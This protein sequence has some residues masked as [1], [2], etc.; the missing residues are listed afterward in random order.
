MLK[1]LLSV[2]LTAIV[3]LTT[4]TAC[5]F[6]FLK[7]DKEKKE[8]K[9]TTTKAAVTTTTTTVDGGIGD[10]TT[11]TVD[12]G[13]DTTTTTTTTASTTV[14]VLLT[15]HTVDLIKGQ[16]L[17]VQLLLSLGCATPFDILPAVWITSFS[18]AGLGLLAAVLLGRVWKT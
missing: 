11:T 2:L 10:T 7:K 18:S 3:L 6:D 17:A 5:S 1:R 13:F 14:G 4:L 9:A 16:Q 12:G 8:E 15:F